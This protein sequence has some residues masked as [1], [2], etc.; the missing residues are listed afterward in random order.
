[1]AESRLR[2]R[3]RTDCVVANGRNRIALQQ[4]NV[5]ECCR[6]IDDLGLKASKNIVEQMNIIHA[7]QH[8]Y[9]RDRLARHIAKRRFEVLLDLEEVVFRRIEQDDS[10]WTGRGNRLH[11]GRSYVSSSSSY[12]DRVSRVGGRKRDAG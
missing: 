6:V 5:L 9:A 2:Q 8:W 11:Q 1:M 3:V 10:A 7:S 12:E 4:R